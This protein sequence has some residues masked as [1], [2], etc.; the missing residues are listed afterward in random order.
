MQNYSPSP[1]SNVEGCCGYHYG[2]R[3]H[4][5]LTARQVG[6]IENNARNE[7]EILKKYIY[8]PIENSLGTTK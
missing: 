4:S 3:H 5:T 1:V 6:S 2:A 8:Q 7:D